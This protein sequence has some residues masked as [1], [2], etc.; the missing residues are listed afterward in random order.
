MSTASSD[1]FRP[2]R[3]AVIPR[4]RGPRGVSREISRGAVGLTGRLPRASQPPRRLSEDS[5]IPPRGCLGAATGI[6]RP[7]AAEDIVPPRGRAQGGCPAPGRWA[8]GL[9]A[10][11]G[12]RVRASGLLLRG[13]GPCPSPSAE[14]VRT[15]RYRSR[16]RHPNRCRARAPL[17]GMS[18][19]LVQ[20]SRPTSCGALDAQSC[21]ASAHTWRSTKSTT[22]RR[23]PVRKKLAPFV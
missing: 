14:A 15:R 22:T 10:A 2:S 13:A 20:T 21:P 23:Q 5:R 9:H 4:G 8:A 12:G 11:A 3:P 16:F 7:R 1:R 6:Y 19:K 17:H 18:S